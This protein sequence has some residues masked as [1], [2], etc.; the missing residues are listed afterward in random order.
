MQKYY[1]DR[2]FNDYQLVADLSGGL[3][4]SKYCQY[5]YGT[6]DIVE[7]GL[8]KCGIVILHNPEESNKVVYINKL[9]CAN[10]SN[11]PLRIEVYPK[12]LIGAKL[13]KATGARTGNSKCLDTVRAQAEIVNGS[14]VKSIEGEPVYLRSIMPYDTSDG[15]PRGSIILYPGSSRIYLLKSLDECESCMGSVCFTWWEEPLC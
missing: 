11:S 15:L 4:Q 5:F 13:E 9:S 14:F 2:K 1:H 6:S 3:H 10:Y 12:A 7:F 8:N